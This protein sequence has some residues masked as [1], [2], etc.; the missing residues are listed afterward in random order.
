M[1]NK[2]EIKGYK[3]IKDLTLELKP[4]NILIGSNGVGKS[5]FIGF[6]K[7]VNTIYEQRLQNFSLSKGA[8]SILSFGRKNTS[9]L[10]GSLEFDAKNAYSFIL[11][12][13]Q[14]N[15]LFVHLEYTYFY[16]SL[17]GSGW[18][19]TLLSSDRSEAFIKNS[20]SAISTHVNDYLKSFRIYHFHDTSENAPLRSPSL[21]D[22]NKYLK[23][24]GGN[25]AS[26]L[27]FLKLRH[28][29]NYN[30]IEKT[31]ESIVP[32]FERFELEPNRLQS[33]S[34]T[35]EWIEKTNPEVYFNASHLSDGSLR[36]IA[37]VTL[38]QQPTLPNTIIIDEPELGLHP[39]AINKLTGLIKSAS[40]RKC[41][42]I[43]STQ[44]INLVNNFLPE[45]IIT[46]DRKEGNSIFNRLVSSDLTEWLEDYSVGE[47]WSKSIIKGQP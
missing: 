14:D 47:L 16:R 10:E 26:Y 45:D 2:I 43:I 44:S 33:N 24:N 38:L 19:E 9:S 17:Y 40:E 8:D 46:V 39:V 42:V 31:I 7:L 22:D 13:T 30:R 15:K 27:Y 41:Q 29:K 20:N 23:E 32:S 1:I 36:F 37:L 25:L 6:F 3:S 28:P 34:I 21:V 35:L 5:N 11:N 12:S 18:K 4:L